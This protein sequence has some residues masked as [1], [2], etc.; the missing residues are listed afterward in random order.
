MKK[1][2]RT[3]Q[4]T[5]DVVL[6]YLAG[7]EPPCVSLYQPTHR[8]NPDNLQDSIR[9]KNLV[10]DIENS[11]KEK[12]PTR[13]VRELIAA[14]RD[15]Q[16]DY[17]FWT[18]QLDGLAVLASAGRFDVFRLPRAVPELAVVA[19]SFHLKP[20]LR[21]TQS[22]DRY[23]VLCL[24]R[25]KARLYEGNR[26]S[27][28]E[29]HPDD[30]PATIE[31][32][33]GDELTEQYL[34]VGAQGAGAPRAAGGGV[35]GSGA[36]P[37]VHAHG[38]KTDEVDIDRDRY[39]RAVD[40][41]VLTYLSNPARVPLVLV[42]PT[43]YHAPFRA[44]SK[45]P[46]LLAGGVSKHPNALTP[47]A[48]RESAWES[49]LP[50]YQERLAGLADDFRVAASRQLAAGKP[51]EVAA[52]AI[53]GRVGTLLV[54]ADRELPGRVDR[55]TGTIQA[56]D[57]SN[58]EVDDAIDDL[59]EEVLRMGGQVVVVPGDQMPTDTGVAAIFRY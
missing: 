5:T 28:D 4:P 38:D 48:L 8:S 56:A 12:Y 10:R 57:L 2:P 51:D 59:A 27:L 9:F 19:D 36:A 33:L 15:L 24:D 6:G 16:D 44:V 37:S 26:Y 52:A 31:L 53:A 23:H 54:D 32:A 13:E 21:H 40:R 14:F 58:P 20:L 49:V 18:H 50:R 17:Q 34:S 22:A 25:H 42:A 35:A 3:K 46:H 11:L 39:F 29:L 41:F 7:T 43:E 45:N 55:A 47:A 1:Q 30:F